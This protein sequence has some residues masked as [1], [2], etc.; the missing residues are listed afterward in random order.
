M[1]L[2]AHATALVFNIAF[3]EKLGIKPVNFNKEFHYNELEKSLKII[4]DIF[5][6]D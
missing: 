4:E 1:N 5:I 6:N 2:R 3:A